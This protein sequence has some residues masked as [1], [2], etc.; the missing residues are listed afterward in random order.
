MSELSNTAVT[1]VIGLSQSRAEIRRKISYYAFSTFLYKL[2]Y[3][4]VFDI[5]CLYNVAQRNFIK[6]NIIQ[7]IIYIDISIYDGPWWFS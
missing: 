5:S 6:I 1:P 4:C 3:M 7:T 2:S